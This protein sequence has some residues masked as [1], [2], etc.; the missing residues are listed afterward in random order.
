MD[1]SEKIEE[2]VLAPVGSALLSRDTEIIERDGW[3]QVITPSTMSTQGNEVAFSRISAHD[4]DGVVLRT[5]DQYAGHRLPFRW[6]LGPLT[7]PRDFAGYLER[8]GFVGWSI[9]GMAI[10]PSAWTRTP[11]E[12][13]SIEP[14]T[15]NNL[16]EYYACWVRGWDISVPDAGAWIDDH[17]RALATGRFHF[18]LAR[19]DGECVG[20]AGLIAKRRSVYL[21]GGNVI[22]SHQHQGVYRAL[23]DERLALART[24]G[25]PVAVTHARE[26]TSA[27]I[28]E[29]LGFESLYTSYVYK[30]EP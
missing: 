11:H 9:R 19:V 20:T 23:L 4:V 6:C 21:V 26:A 16:A 15:E 8:H 13:V 29:K 1:R 27:P 28:L 24:L 7:E 5:V 12:R 2:T 22:A 14:V 30:W 3:Y 25:A 17:R 18:F 10:E